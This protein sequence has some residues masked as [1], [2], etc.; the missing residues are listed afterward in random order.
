[1]AIEPGK[2]SELL[3]LRARVQNVVDQLRVEK[4]SLCNNLSRTVQDIA[5]MDQQISR[6]ERALN[7]ID[8]DE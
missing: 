5:A 7:R 1:M 6:L 3:V 2:N 4:A 8:D